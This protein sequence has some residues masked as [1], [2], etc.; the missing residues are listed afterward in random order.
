GGADL[1]R[2]ESGRRVRRAQ[3]MALPVLVRRAQG[4]IVHGTGRPTL[5][6]TGVG[7]HPEDIRGEGLAVVALQTKLVGGKLQE[8]VVGPRSSQPVS[9]G[10]WR[11]GYRRVAV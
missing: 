9:V 6:G 5:S 11:R 10:L 3:G 7:V 4:R 2:I 1:R 8:V